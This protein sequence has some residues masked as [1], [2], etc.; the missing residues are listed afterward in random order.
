M[1]V[2]LTPKVKQPV[3]TAVCRRAYLLRYPP[4]IRAR[5][6]PRFRR[7]CSAPGYSRAGAGSRPPPDCAGRCD[8]WRAPGDPVAP[9][10]PVVPTPPAESVAP[11]AHARLRTPRA[12]ERRAGTAWA[13][14]RGA[15]SPCQALPRP[16]RR[17]QVG[18]GNAHAPIVFISPSPLDAAATS[19][20][21]FA[22]W[23]DREAMLEHH[24]TSE[25][26]HPYF[27]FVRAVV[28]G[29]RRRL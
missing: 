8:R 13:P 7:R 27:Q 20:E 28:D 1:V 10:K 24:L 25:T 3:L 21:A 29:A 26:P 2:G 15:D 11:P 6:R 22:E 19:N 18:F 4:G 9:L 14:A 16:L 5:S 23:L 17:P 12:L